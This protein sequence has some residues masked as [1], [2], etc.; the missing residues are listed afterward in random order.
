M[1][2]TANTE[3]AEPPDEEQE[4]EYEVELTLYYT[5]WVAVE[6]A[7]EDEARDLAMEA[8]LF[9]ID[10]ADTPFTRDVDAVRLVVQS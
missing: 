4:R 10:L 5:G 7:S 9:Q 2:D 1:S 6:A 8:D 3:A